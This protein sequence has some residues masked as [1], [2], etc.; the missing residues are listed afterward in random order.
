[1]TRTN[2]GNRTT[3]ALTV[4]A[5]SLALVTPLVSTSGASASS[6]PL[7]LGA[8]T[9]SSAF[10]LDITA[11][12]WSTEDGKP[13]WVVTY[14][15]PASMVDAGAAVGTT[16]ADLSGGTSSAGA[17]LDQDPIDWALG[18]VFVSADENYSG[19]SV[20]A[21]VDN[22][23]GT[24]LCVSMR[25]PATPEAIA[26][27]GDTEV[28]GWVETYSGCTTIT[29]TVTSV[30]PT[31]T[32]LSATRIAGARPVGSV[33]R[34]RVGTVLTLRVARVFPVP[35]ATTIQWYANG[36]RIPRAHATHLRVTRALAGKALTARVG[37][38]HRNYVHRIMRTA[39]VL[40]R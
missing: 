21:M 36:V 16:A 19:P 25:A 13:G 2:L 1:M 9:A 34:A 5:A 18:E 11:I 32:T 4:L 6:A 27:F 12:A 39:R 35:D 10:P 3:G 26:E 15:V 40:V 7:T 20:A 24:E 17:T 8:S 14:P 37:V 38:T 33:L 28:N 30:A 23:A 22:A 29:D 31:F